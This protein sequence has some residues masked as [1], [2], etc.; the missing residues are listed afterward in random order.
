MSIQIEICE[1]LI[2]NLNWNLK[3]LFSI[4]RIIQKSKKRS[5]CLL[6]NPLHQII[7]STPHPAALETGEKTAVKGVIYYQEKHIRNL[8]M[9]GGIEGTTVPR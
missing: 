6:W 5:I 9:S 2:W 4:H 3:L 8:K 7:Q 1:N